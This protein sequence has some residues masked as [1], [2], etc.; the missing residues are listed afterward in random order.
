MVA[1]LAWLDFGDP[2]LPPTP[3]GSRTGGRLTTVTLGVNWYLS[4]RARLMVNYVHAMPTNL[5]FG[6]STAESVT[7]RTAVFW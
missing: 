6:S 1:W 3:S 5:T 7:V 2:D 4:D